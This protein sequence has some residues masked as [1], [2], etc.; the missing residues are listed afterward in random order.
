MEKFG[1][2]VIKKAIGLALD[3]AKGISDALAGDGKIGWFEALGLVGNTFPLAD[4]INRRKQ[5]ISEL[6]DLDAAEKMELSNWVAEHYDIPDNRVETTVEKALD[7]FFNLLD[8]SLEMAEVW[9]K[10]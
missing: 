4:V 7:L 3:L 9:R 10:P 6:K 1:I 2:D 5:L 8:F